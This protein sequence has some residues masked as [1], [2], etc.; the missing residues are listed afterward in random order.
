[1]NLRGRLFPALVF[2]AALSS[3]EVDADD[4][5]SAGPL[6]LAQAPECLCAPSTARGLGRLLLD[7]NPIN[8]ADPQTFADFQANIARNSNV[9]QSNGATMICARRLGAALQN[10][11]LS[12]FS[13]QDYNEAYGSVLAQGGTIEMAQDVADSMSS[14][15]VDMWATGRELSWLAQV[16][17]TAANGNWTPYTTTGTESRNQIRQI[18]PIMATISDIGRDLPWV[19]DTI[20]GFQ[21]IVEEQ[22]VMAA[23]LFRK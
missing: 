5:S 6:M 12:Q 9:L 21:P 13:K 10:Q 1:M 16:I 19:L 8:E 22:M 2:C 20:N 14:G 17:P 11:G 4:P 18:L 23:C 15:A 7:S 3:C